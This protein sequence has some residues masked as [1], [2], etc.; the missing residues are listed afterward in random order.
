MASRDF[1]RA[2]A[3]YEAALR[4]SPDNAR[5]YAERGLSWAIKLDYDRAIAD[6]DEAL[7]H[8]PPDYVEIIKINRDAAAAAMPKPVAPLPAASPAPSSAP[9]PPQPATVSRPDS[10][11]PPASALRDLSAGAG[12]ETNTDCSRAE[13]HWKV[14]DD[15]KSVKAYEDHIARFPSCE[16]ADLANAD[17]GVEEVMGQTTEQ[18][19]ALQKQCPRIA[20]GVPGMRWL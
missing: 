9:S 3:D 6:F 10:Q 17:R 5:V 20:S 13:T 15:I 18:N 11:T 16:F 7:R 14:A 12:E 19:A 1:N 2:L 4:I 8:A